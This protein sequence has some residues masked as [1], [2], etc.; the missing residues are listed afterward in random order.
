MTF[1]G[2]E[3]LSPSKTG[4]YDMR[5]SGGTLW[6][7]TQGLTSHGAKLSG[8]SAHLDVDGDILHQ[9]QSWGMAF[10]L[11]FAKNQLNGLTSGLELMGYGYRNTQNT[12][13]APL[14]KATLTLNAVSYT[15]LTLPTILLV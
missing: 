8:P 11:R 6:N 2:G 15:H 13:A 10:W 3:T 12:V 4:S 9:K 1:N 7:P 5:L 14:F